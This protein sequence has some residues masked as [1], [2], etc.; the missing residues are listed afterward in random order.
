MNAV[1]SKKDGQTI[2][3]VGFIV[4]EYVPE[5]ELFD[6]VS[7]GCFSED[8]C[9]YYFRQMLSALSYLHLNGLAHSGLSLHK[10][11]L[12]DELNLRMI[13]LDFVVST[14]E[15]LTRE[16]GTPGYMAPEIRPGEK[17]EG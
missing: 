16:R 3:V 13:S 12:D 7:L 5:G 10:F 14:Q 11:M 4:I 9:R 1:Y 8:V 17:F 6:Y 2:P 15:P